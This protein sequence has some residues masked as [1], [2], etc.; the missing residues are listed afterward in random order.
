MLVLLVC[1]PCWTQTTVPGQASTKGLCSVANTGSDNKIQITCG[2]GKNQGQKMLAILNKILANQLD[3]DAVMGKLDEI[4]EDVEQLRKHPPYRYPSL[5]KHTIEVLAVALS[6]APGPGAVSVSTR[7]PT[8]DITDFAVTLLNMFHAAHWS[9]QGPNVAIRPPDMGDSG[10]I[11]I[12]TG[13]HIHAT[14][15][16]AALAL[17]VQ[18]QL[19]D[20]ANI[21]SI[22]DKGESA[23]GYDL[24][25][26]VGPAPE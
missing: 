24:S 26:F 3:P 20:I 18:E 16:H 6:K 7:N 10:V 14:S 21:D 23:S 19:K 15:Q 13:L 9:I 17:F 11:P 5:D 12:P 8:S 4:K 2:I 1:L 22:V 25:L